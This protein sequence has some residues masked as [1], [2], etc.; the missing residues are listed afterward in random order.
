MHGLD[1][2]EETQKCALKISTRGGNSN[3]MQ[4]RD[5]IDAALETLKKF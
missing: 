1:R 5:Q 4:G 3:N 2:D